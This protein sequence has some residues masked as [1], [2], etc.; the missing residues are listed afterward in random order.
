MLTVKRDVTTKEHYLIVKRHGNPS[1]MHY[2][3]QQTKKR[4]KQQ[5]PVL[6]Q[7][8]LLY[9]FLVSFS[10]GIRKFLQKVVLKFQKSSNS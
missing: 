7:Q 5:L 2:T 8:T 6:F 9:T 1:N 4:L 3:G 10:P